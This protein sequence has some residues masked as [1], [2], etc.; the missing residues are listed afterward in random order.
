MVR[1]AYAQRSSSPA[2]IAEGFPSMIRV[3]AGPPHARRD[4]ASAEDPD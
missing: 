1:R 4:G 3:S 2:L